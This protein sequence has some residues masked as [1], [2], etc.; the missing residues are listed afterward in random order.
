[1]AQLNQ[2]YKVT[3]CGYCHASFF[4]TDKEQLNQHKVCMSKPNSVSRQFTMTH[5]EQ[6]QLFAPYVTRKFAPVQLRLIKLEGYTEK[7]SASIIHKAFI[8]QKLKYLA[9]LDTEQESTACIEDNTTM[10]ILG[11]RF[12]FTEA[13]DALSNPQNSLLVFI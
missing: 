1:M 7:E 13:M 4:Y 9:K 2:K 3:T 11:Q 10:W 5:E 8:F 12:S 6:A